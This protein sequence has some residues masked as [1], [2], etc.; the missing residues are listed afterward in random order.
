MNDPGA[1][2]RRPAGV[3]L[4]VA[5][6]RGEAGQR[7]MVILRAPG[8]AFARRTGGCTNCGFWQHLTTDGAPVSAGDLL[9]QLTSAFETHREASPA[10]RQLDIFCSGSFLCDGEVP[11]EARAPLLRLATQELPG[12][13]AVMIESRPEYI[14][15]DAI[16]PLAA[17]LPSPDMLE[18]GIGLESADPVIREQ[19]IRKG[20]TLE[21][22]A[23][24]ARVLA[25][26]GVGLA[27]YLLL[28]PL[29]TGELDAARD[30]VASGEYLADL[31]RAL[32]LQLRVA[33]EPTFVP[34]QTPLYEEM[35]QG[36]YTPPSL[37]TVV[38]VTR[39]LAK[40]GLQVHV[41]LSSEGLPTEQAPTGC[42]RCTEQLRTALAHFNETQTVSAL[43]GLS[44]QCQTA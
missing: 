22:F 16:A 8:C 4:G 31:G 24:A 40:L 12:L 38:Q 29:G 34:E 33:L 42:P 15:P 36:R 7:L 11:P 27:V 41:G 23:D 28:K 20:F 35:K 10:V 1:W 21:A 44:C 39:Q 32:G 13:R 43:Q 30:V 3:E 25:D 5:S 18:V 14:T 9:A 6:A 19:R 37:W 2:S 17:A 26:A